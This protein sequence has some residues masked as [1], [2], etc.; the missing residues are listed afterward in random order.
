MYIA[1]KQLDEEEVMAAVELG[2]ELDGLPGNSR[3]S[4]DAFL[5]ARRHIMARE[6]GL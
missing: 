3:C 6:A 5:K 1:G 2:A 4:L